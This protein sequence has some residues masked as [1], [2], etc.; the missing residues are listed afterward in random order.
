MT[1]LS[2]LGA[3]DCMAL[4]DIDSDGDLDVVTKF[5]LT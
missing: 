1:A 5:L 2:V 4:V 3:T